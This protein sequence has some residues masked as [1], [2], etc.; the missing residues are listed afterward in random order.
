[1]QTTE[2]IINQEKF[3]PKMLLGAENCL[4]HRWHHWVWRWELLQCHIS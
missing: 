2:R 4:C 3:P 1:M